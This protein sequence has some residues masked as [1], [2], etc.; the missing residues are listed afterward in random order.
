MSSNNANNDDNI[1]KNVLTDVNKVER[2][3][4]G[5]TYKYYANINTPSAIGMSDKGDLTTLSKDV[6]GLISYVELLVQGSGPAS[7]TGKPLGN[8]FFL[9]TGAKCKDKKTKKTEDRY[10]YV[11]NV[12]T[13]NIPFIS[14]GLGVNFSEFKGLVPGAL[15]DL[16]EIN[17]FR[18]MQAFLSGSTPECQKLKMET[19]DVHNNRSSETHYV[20]TVDIQNMDPCIFSNGTNPINKRKCVQ[21]FTPMQPSFDNNDFYFQDDDNEL[22]SFQDDDDELL[23]P[24]DPI[25]QLYLLSLSFLAIYLLCRIKKVI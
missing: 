23:F 13:G 18:L 15:T 12:A 22:L 19:I 24:K 2:K 1:F 7:K 21:A 8:K 11:N 9:K 14:S 25:N 4:L 5:P 3:L 17:P 20:T 10:I 6:N 16:N